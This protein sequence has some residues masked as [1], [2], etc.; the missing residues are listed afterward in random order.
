MSSTSTIYT[1][2][3]LISFLLCL[4]NGGMSADITKRW[5]LYVPFTSIFLV[6]GNL[7]IGTLSLTDGLFFIAHYVNYSLNNGNCSRQDI[8]SNVII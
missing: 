4:Y 3:I 8:Q 5:L 2:I 6:P 7:L 1:L